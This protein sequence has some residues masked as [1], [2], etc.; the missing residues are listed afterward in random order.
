MVLLNLG[1]LV[2][3]A[4]YFNLSPQTTLHVIDSHRPCNL[5]NL[6]SAMP[7]AER[8]VVWDDGDVDEDMREEKLAFEALQVS[9]LCFLSVSHKRADLGLPAHSTSQKATLSPNMKIQMTRICTGGSDNAAY[10]QT[11]KSLP[12]HPMKTR[13]TNSPELRKIARNGQGP[14]LR[15]G[16][17]DVWILK[18]TRLSRA[19]TMGK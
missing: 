1:S 5:D 16:N 19:Q 15:E 8:V 12:H 17:G 3:L 7:D 6:F 4:Q 2:D 10:L 9:S 18:A 13:T 14:P 11:A